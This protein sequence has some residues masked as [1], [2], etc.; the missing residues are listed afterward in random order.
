MN[1]S[2]VARGTCLGGVL[3]TSLAGCAGVQLPAGSAPAATYRLDRAVKPSLHGFQERVVYSFMG[4]DDGQ[5][6]AP[7]DAPLS[8]FNGVLYGTTASGGTSGCAAYGCGI[9][10]SVSQASSG[11]SEKVL[12]RF[13]G[14]PDGGNPTGPIIHYNGAWYGLTNSGGADNY[15]AVF[16]LTD[17]GKERV[18]YSFKDGA[19]GAYPFGGL[20]AYQGRLYGT[21]SYGG[22]HNVGTVFAVTTSGNEKILHSFEFKNG[23]APYAGLTLMNGKFYGTTID[24]GTDGYGTVFEVEPSGSEKV[25]YSFQYGDDG[26]SPQA[27]LTVIAG[28]L[29]GT[30]TDGGGSGYNGTAFEVSPA[31]TE[32]IL[33]RFALSATDGYFPESTLLYRS[34]LLYG[35]TSVGGRHGVGVVFRLKMSGSEE[36]LHS[37]QGAPNDGRYPTGGLSVLGTNLYGTAYEGGTGDCAYE[38]GCGVVFALKPN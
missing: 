37:F 13:A 17:A 32:Q 38:D 15:G 24:G 5:Y 22:S 23:A 6:P 26:A 2:P 33:H 8:V 28:N 29:Y 30:T 4:G 16:A 11:V 21:T 35:T 25:V 10:F 34:G 12:Y 27:P 1:I 31:G 3:L 9:V 36:I 18:V 19:D 14:E 20:V 7:E